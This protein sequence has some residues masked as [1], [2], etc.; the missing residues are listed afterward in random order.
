V[1]AVKAVIVRPCP[2]A[3]RCRCA[4]GMLDHAGL[5]TVR[6]WEWRAL[7]YVH[8]DEYCGLLLMW[9]QV[10]LLRQTSKCRCLV[11]A[12]F[13][14]GCLYEVS[15]NRLGTGNARKIGRLRQG[16]REKASL[17]G[18]TRCAA[19]PDMRHYVCR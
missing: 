10:V 4:V 3:S 17:A 6:S 13:G 9:H 19:V 5:I 8:P 11:H 2:T 1:G 12:L 14:R 15:Y 16:L 7:T 18:S